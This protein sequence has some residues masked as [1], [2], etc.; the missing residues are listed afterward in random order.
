[1]NIILVIFRFLSYSKAIFFLR[2]LIT[3]RREKVKGYLI[4]LGTGHLR[5]SRKSFSRAVLQ[6]RGNISR[7]VSLCNVALIWELSG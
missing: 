6:K 4:R 3:S 7:T 5:C 2:D 1:M